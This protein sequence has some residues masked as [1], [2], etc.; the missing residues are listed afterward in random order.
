[1]VRNPYT[2]AEKFQAR[3]SDAADL[4]YLIEPEPGSF[5]LSAEG[6]RITQDMIR[7]ARAAMVKSDP[8]PK[9]DS[10]QLA[11]FLDRLVYASLHT[12]PP[13]QPWS[14]RGS[15]KLMPEINPPMPFIEQAF[16]CLWA[17]RDDAHL[18]AWQFA[19]VTATAFEMLS[20]LWR[21][22]A[23]SLDSVHNHLADRGHPREIYQLALAELVERNFVTGT[24]SDLS[25][26]EDGRLFRNQVEED[27]ERFFFVPW[28]SLSYLEKT[29]M[30]GLLIR[31]RDGLLSQVS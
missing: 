14:I 23:N 12:P 6:R 2:A 7:T 28:R 5:R 11:M 1:M 19:G 13:P 21:N 25:V 30:S 9:E 10:A 24:E 31:L 8:L 27:T 26:T 16:T 15:F 17:Y 18:A 3:L 29:M 20:L 4:E 22:E